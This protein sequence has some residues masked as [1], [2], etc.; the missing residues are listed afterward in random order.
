MIIE[1]I[2]NNFCKIVGSGF[3][4][5]SFFVIVSVIYRL[6]LDR[7]NNNFVEK[8]HIISPS[9]SVGMLF[10]VIGCCLYFKLS[11]IIIFKLVFFLVFFY[12]SS[13]ISSYNI[14][15]IYHLINKK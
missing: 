15:K 4:A 10:F 11:I 2:I 13:V 8:L 9:D 12:F 1:F 14:S 5:I 7:K 6:I 3:F